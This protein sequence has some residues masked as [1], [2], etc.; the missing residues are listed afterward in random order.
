MTYNNLNRFSQK[1]TQPLT[2]G[3]SQAMLY[4]LGL[5]KKDLKKAQIGISSVWLEGNPCNNH[6]NKLSELAKLAIDDYKF[7]NMIGLRFNT[8]GVSDGISMGTSGM[9]YSLPSREI[10]S[11]SIES[12]MKA[13]HYDGNISIAGCDKNLPGCLMG[14]LKV[15]R[16]GLI[17]YGG[18]TLPGNLNGKKID[19]VNAFQSYGELKSG[20]INHEERDNILKRSCPG[21]GSCGGMY[22][23]N[24]MAVALEAMG[25]TQMYDSSNPALSLEK[26]DQVNSLGSVM[27]DLLM[28][29]IKPK[30]IVTKKSLINGLKVASSLGGST[31][32]II[33]I[34]AIAYA[35]DIDIKLDEIDKILN[36]VPLIGNMKPFGKYLMNDLHNIGGTP[37]VLKYLIEEDIIDGDILTVSCKTLKKNLLSIRTLELRN[38]EN[39]KKILKIDNPIKKNSHIQ[40][41]YGNI[42]PDGCIGKITGKEGSYFLGK[43]LVFDSENEFMLYINK[44]DNKN[45]I[46]LKDDNIVVIIRYVGPK[47]GPGMPEMLNPTSTIVGLGL[48]KKVALITD[49]RFSGGSHGFIIGHIAP[50]A[51]VGGP[52]AFVKDGDSI[53]I[54]AEN[55]SINVINEEFTKDRDIRINDYYDNLQRINSFKCDGYLNKYRKLVEQSNYGCIME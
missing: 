14:L 8:I 49:G 17:V 42:A 23:A 5:S 27:H 15:N 38:N 29:N 40:I 32:I 19:I 28:N 30:D 45:K 48:E 36:D 4:A 10:I 44:E 22:T 43:A 35:A 31:N 21:S 9:R 2:Q 50:E 51:Y 55:K 34:L 54:D 13:Q 18:S 47:G 37:L 41:F 53:E 11:D 7:E 6:L 25:I 26:I 20:K 3:A 33:H 12:V 46:L 24:S 52:L 39:F 16:P 1:I